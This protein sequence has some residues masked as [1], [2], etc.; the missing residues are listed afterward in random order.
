MGAAHSLYSV[1]SVS[2]YYL[3]MDAQDQFKT[4]ITT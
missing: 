2:H 1:I 4:F 3:G